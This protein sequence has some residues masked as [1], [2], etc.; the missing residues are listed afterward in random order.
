MCIFDDSLGTT[1]SLKT[2]V[3]DKAILISYHNIGFY[4]ELTKIIS[5]LSS[6]NMHLVSFVK[7]AKVEMNFFFLFKMYFLRN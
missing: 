4:V 2:F 7:I 5:L 6:S 3:V 1:F